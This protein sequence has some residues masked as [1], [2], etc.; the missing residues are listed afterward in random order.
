MNL[1]NNQITVE[2]LLSNPKVKAVFQREIPYIVNHP[3][4]SLA[5]NL[6]LCDVLIFA[7]EYLP[8]YKIDSMLKEIQSI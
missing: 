1:K 7:K 5:N 4:I 2:E 6:K 3:K 8:Q